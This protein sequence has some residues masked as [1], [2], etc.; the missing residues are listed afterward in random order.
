MRVSAQSLSVR[1][2]PIVGIVLLSAGC[3]PIPAAC[4][5]GPGC[6]GVYVLVSG[7]ADWTAGGNYVLEMGGDAF[8]IDQLNGGGVAVVATAASIRVRLIRPADCVTLVSFEAPPS[9]SWI[10]RF[11]AD[12]K[13]TREQLAQG[14]ILLL[15]PALVEGELSGCP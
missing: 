9:S 7:P 10:I 8:P 11:D 5:P 13:P 15:G 12:E 3:Q 6:D 4:A 1:L 14:D 2:V